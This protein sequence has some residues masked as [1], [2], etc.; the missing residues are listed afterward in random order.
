MSET[1]TFG[2]RMFARVSKDL[3]GSGNLTQVWVLKVIA[4]PETDNHHAIV[5]CFVGDI[6]VVGNQRLPNP[7]GN[8]K[9]IRETELNGWSG[10]P[11][12]VK[13]E[14]SEMVPDGTEVMS[15]GG[16]TVEL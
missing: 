15:G 1:D 10:V 9:C 14:L 2:C 11:E 8:G 16:E 13:E 4:K 12:D 5:E 3:P 7:A 6:N